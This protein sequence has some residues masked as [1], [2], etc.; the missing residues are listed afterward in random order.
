[1]SEAE[2]LIRRVMTAQDRIDA[3]RPEEALALLAEPRA[4]ADPDARACRASAHLALGGFEAALAEADA[5]AA[6]NPKNAAAQF[7]RGRALSALERAREAA[8]AFALAERVAPGVAEIP[9]R[10]GRS[11]LIAGEGREA[12]SAL[13]RAL[14]LNPVHMDA[15]DAL[16]EWLAASGRG[17]ELFALFDALDRARP[18]HP[19]PLHRKARAALHFERLEEAEATIALARARFAQ[20]AV[21]DPIDAELRRRRREFD[22]AIRLARGAAARDF[23][24]GAPTLA[25]ALLETGAARE[26]LDLCARALAAARHD[27]FWL[28]MASTALSALRDPRLAGLAD[29]AAWPRAFALPAPAGYADIAAF[30][31]ALARALLPLHERS[32]EPLAQSVRGGTQTATPL[33]VSPDP[34]LR[35]FFALVAPAVDAYIADMPDQK[36]HPF[37]GRR[38]RGWRI[39]GSWSVR[40]APGGRHAPH[41]HDAGWI[42]SAYYVDTPGSAQRSPSGEG[43]LEFGRPPM[44]APGIEGPFARV[45]PIPGTLVLFPSYFWHG[46]IP[47][48]GEAS[49]LTIAFDIAP[50]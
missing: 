30:N 12:E 45:A 5:G 24:A 2:A 15:L 29:F 31:A 19:G 14:A 23:T 20:S 10:R 35:A 37:F 40:L 1:M 28:A 36:D 43:W 4:D 9:A 41:A 46:T 42:S 16:T 38:A 47:F 27:Q 17:G 48:G 13:R 25:R 49:R 26:A 34:V 44:N 32:G 18:D 8:D 6:L 3:G 33:H 21:F 39:S 7:N 11:L 22:A 50:K